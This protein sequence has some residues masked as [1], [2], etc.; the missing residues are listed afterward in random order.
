MTSAGISIGK[1][2]NIS[3][4]GINVGSAIGECGT[5]S[6]PIFGSSNGD[7]S[8][9]SNLVGGKWIGKQNPCM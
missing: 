2:N 8:Q 4:H 5:F 9:P 1:S 6:G 7:S 3:S